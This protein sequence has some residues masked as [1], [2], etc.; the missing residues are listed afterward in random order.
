MDFNTSKDEAVKAVDRR[1][2]HTAIHRQKKEYLQASTIAVKRVNIILWDF[3]LQE[4][5]R[6][7][8]LEKG[9]TTKCTGSYK[10][11]ERSISVLL[12]CSDNQ[13]SLLIKEDTLVDL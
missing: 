3:L 7:N 11:S 13:L 5:L 2:F 9:K 10:K 4:K 6:E 8:S 12:S 1:L